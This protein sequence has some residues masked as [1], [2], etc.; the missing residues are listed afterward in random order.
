[1]LVDNAN[2]IVATFDLKGRFTSVNPAIERI[3]GFAPAEVIGSLLRYHVPQEQFRTHAE[4]LNRKLK[5][6]QARST[7]SRCSQRSACDGY[8]K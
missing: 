3:L 6:P 1:M 2:D 7:R 8:L 5:W 4:M